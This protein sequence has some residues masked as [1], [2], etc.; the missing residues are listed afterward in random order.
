V[1]APFYKTAISFDEKGKKIKLYHEQ[2]HISVIGTEY[3]YF[4]G[5]KVVMP[6]TG[7]TYRYDLEA[8]LHPFTPQNK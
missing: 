4:N 5:V 2:M 6:K 8:T 1:Y 3:H 7:V